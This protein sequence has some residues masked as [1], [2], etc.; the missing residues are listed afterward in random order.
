MT[1][2]S[3]SYQV[4]TSDLKF[5]IEPKIRDC[6]NEVQASALNTEVSFDEKNQISNSSASESVIEEKQNSSIFC[7]TLTSEQCS[8]GPPL[9]LAKNFLPSFKQPLLELNSAQN[10]VLPS[11]SDLR[12]VSC[13]S[14]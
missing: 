7:S 5:V 3:E 6:D 8:R 13:S 4:S 9:L 14:K 2:M 1:N 11:T 12:L 10:N